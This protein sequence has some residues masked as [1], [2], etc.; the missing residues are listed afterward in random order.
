MSFIHYTLVGHFDPRAVHRS[1]EVSRSID[2]GQVD[3][4]LAQ[5]SAGSAEFVSI[6]NGYARCQ[7]AP[8]GGLMEAVREFAYRLASETHCLAVE[9]MRV[10]GF[11]PEAVAAQQAEWDRLLAEQK[12]AE[13]SVEGDT[14]FTPSV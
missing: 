9:N 2:P 8:A 1:L 5:Y 7:W 4:L 10:V 13:P 14:G 11:P 12:H 3:R 6:G